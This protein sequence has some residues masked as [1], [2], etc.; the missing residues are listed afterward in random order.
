MCS[1]RLGGERAHGDGGGVRE[2]GEGEGGGTRRASLTIV[3]RPRGNDSKGPVTATANVL[4]RSPTAT[5][6]IGI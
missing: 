3:F 2:S 1:S 5:T 4:D 6:N